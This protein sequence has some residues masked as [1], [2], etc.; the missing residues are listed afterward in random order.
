MIKKLFR[1]WCDKSALGLPHIEAWQAAIYMKNLEKAYRAGFRG[2]KEIYYNK[3][4]R[5]DDHE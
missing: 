5:G 3:P 1:K 2:A 4:V